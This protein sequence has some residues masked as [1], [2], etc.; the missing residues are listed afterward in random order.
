MDYDVDEDKL[1]AL[2]FS[3][4]GKEYA[5]IF[6]TET[7]GKSFPLD[8]A[9]LLKDQESDPSFHRYLEKDR[10]K[11]KKTNS[12]EARYGCMKVKCS[13]PPYINVG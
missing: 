2:T 12:M 4:V 11:F 1:D 7:N 6:T 13:C 8:M 10:K 9:T 5:D 3:K